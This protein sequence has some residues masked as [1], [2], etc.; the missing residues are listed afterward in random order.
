MPFQ[1]VIGTDFAGPF[2]YRAKKTQKESKVYILIFSFSVSRVVHLELIPN[3]RT[4]EFI[5]CLKRLIPRIG[6]S[7]TIYSDNTKSFQ[8]AAKLVK[9]DYQK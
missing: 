5:K 2:Y 6:K 1:V 8:A 3:K 9:A 4:Q 7:S